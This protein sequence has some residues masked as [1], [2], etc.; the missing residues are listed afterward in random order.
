MSFHRANSSWNGFDFYKILFFLI[1]ILFVNFT[2][3]C[4]KAA[5]FT[6]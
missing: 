6:L 3:S 2:K 1:C 4:C 5:H